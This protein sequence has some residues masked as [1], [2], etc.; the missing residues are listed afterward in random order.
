[1]SDASF[2]KRFAALYVRSVHS[3]FSYFAKRVEDRDTAVELT[4]E[5]FARSFERHDRF[6]GVDEHREINLL[7]SVAQTVLAEHAKAERLER[8]ALARIGFD[9]D[10]DPDQ[11]LDRIESHDAIELVRE[12]V[13]ETLAALPTD[14]PYALRRRLVDELNYAEISRELGVSPGRVRTYV[15]RAIQRFKMSDSLRAA[16][17]ALEL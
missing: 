3:V 1:V 12:R 10:E 15:S 14:Q 5:T 11:P 16:V 13:R 9:P 4:S 17:D 8:A 6:C 2:D 7:F